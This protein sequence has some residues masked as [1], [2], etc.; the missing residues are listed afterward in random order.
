MALSAE[1]QEKVDEIKALQA[2]IKNIFTH[3]LSAQNVGLSPIYN[4]S[5]ELEKKVAELEAL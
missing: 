2:E 1:Q 5:L 3:S 4:M